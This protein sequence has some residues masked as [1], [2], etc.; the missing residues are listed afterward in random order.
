MIKYNLRIYCL[1]IFFGVYFM[2]LFFQEPIE[3]EQCVFPQ[4]IVIEWDVKTVINPRTHAPGKIEHVCFIY[5]AALNDS[6]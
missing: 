2:L 5:A 6:F 4:V 1:F 3:P